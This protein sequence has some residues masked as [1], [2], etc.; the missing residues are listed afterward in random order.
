MPNRFAGHFHCDFP[1]SPLAVKMKESWGCSSAG[2]APRSQRGG[3]RFDPAQLHQENQQLIPKVRKAIRESQASTEQRGNAT[4]LFLPSSQTKRLQHLSF[5]ILQP[6]ERKSPTSS[7]RGSAV[8]VPLR[9]ATFMVR[10]EAPANKSLPA[11]LV[12]Q[13]RLA[14]LRLSHIQATKYF[15]KSI[16]NHHNGG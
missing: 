7:P 6:I 5:S 14:L 15:V 3:Q 4:P 10:F 1:D 8:S 13:L 2:R 16:L 9:S 11:T 12:P